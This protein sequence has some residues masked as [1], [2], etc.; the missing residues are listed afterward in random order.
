M[1]IVFCFILPYYYESFK[2]KCANLNIICKENYFIFNINDNFYVCIHPSQQNNGEQIFVNKDLIK[3][4]ITECFNTINIKGF[5]IWIFLHHA[6]DNSMGNEI[7]SLTEKLKS[8][9]DNELVNFFNNLMRENNKVIIN[10]NDPL[11]IIATPGGRPEWNMSVECQYS[12]KKL[13]KYQNH[14]I[15]EIDNKSYNDI[16]IIEFVIN[17]FRVL[18]VKEDGYIKNENPTGIDDFLKAILEYNN[19][20]NIPE[21]YIAVHDLNSYISD[22]FQFK[23]KVDYICD[24]HHNGKYRKFTDAIIKFLDL[25][26]ENNTVEAIN[27]CKEIEKL[28]I[29]LSKQTIKIYSLLKHRIMTSFLDLDIDWQGIKEVNEKD[30]ENAKEYLNDILKGKSNNYYRQKLVN[31]WFY[32]TGN[33]DLKIEKTEKGIKEKIENIYSSLKKDRIPYEKSVL[34]LINELTN[35]TKENLKKRWRTLLEHVG[36]DI[37]NNNES[38]FDNENITTKKKSS[39]IDYL[40]NLDSMIKGEKDINKF[41]SFN[42]HEWYLKLG[43]LLEELKSFLE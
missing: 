32:L 37:K 43:D 17:D 18:F 16:N 11:I 26:N 1:I 39:I 41:L 40:E 12:G 42:F 31:L 10:D 24:F 25:I 15:D 29:E 2:N 28:I 35:E 20:K 3:K 8:I 36:L 23:D 27:K 14:K 33:E 6:A 9:K 30:K 13:Y 22:I 19:W 4:I 34:D 38:F 21:K 7:K 5:Q